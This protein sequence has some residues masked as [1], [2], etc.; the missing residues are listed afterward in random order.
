MK[1]KLT[2]QFSNG[3]ELFTEKTF[4][5]IPSDRSCLRRARAWRDTFSELKY[6]SQITGVNPSVSYSSLDAVE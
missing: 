5:P 1:F 3:V 6:K 2:I 4:S